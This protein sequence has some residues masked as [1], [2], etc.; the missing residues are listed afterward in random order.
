M[1]TSRLQVIFLRHTWQNKL[2]VYLGVSGWVAVL[3][4]ND[5]SGLRRPKNVKFG[6]KV[7]SSMR[8]MHALRFLEKVFNC[9]KIGKNR[10]K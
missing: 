7:V 5:T 4:L 1:S 10:Q 8:M 3:S 9:G 6:I 2:G